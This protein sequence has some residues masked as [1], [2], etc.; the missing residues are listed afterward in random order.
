[1]VPKSR[2]AFLQP[3]LAM[4]ISSLLYVEQTHEPVIVTNKCETDSCPYDHY[5]GAGGD[6]YNLDH[7][8]VLADTQSKYITPTHLLYC[9]AI[10]EL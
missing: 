9:R 6:G 10:H 2:F 8:S 1:M 3:A 4:S 5:S 7:L